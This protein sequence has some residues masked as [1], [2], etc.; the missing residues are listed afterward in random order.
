MSRYYLKRDQNE[1]ITKTMVVVQVALTVRGESN[2]FLSVIFRG[3][4]E[5]SIFELVII[6]FVTGIS[7]S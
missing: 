7:A 6:Y 3:I 1:R 5:F 4:F 2:H